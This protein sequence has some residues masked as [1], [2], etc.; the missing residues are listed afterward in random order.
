M[1]D[2]HHQPWNGAVY[3]ADGSSSAGEPRPDEPRREGIGLGDMLEMGLESL[4]IHFRRTPEDVT[5][6][7][8]PTDAS[9]AH[10]T[11]NEPNR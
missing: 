7:P 2:I 5:P 11:D 6:S 9:E 4:L 1:N 10:R 3:S 8:E